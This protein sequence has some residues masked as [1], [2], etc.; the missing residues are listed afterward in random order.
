[1]F[2]EFNDF[3]KTIHLS[4]DDNYSFKKEKEQSHH[5]LSLI[6]K[7]NDVLLCDEMIDII[8]QVKKG[9]VSLDQA[10][11]KIEKK[12]ETLLGENACL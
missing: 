11:I 1:M 5:Y 2:T 6:K 4:T 12:K 9:M 3:E 8:K 7:N 10:L